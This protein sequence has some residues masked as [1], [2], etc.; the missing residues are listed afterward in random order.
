MRGREPLPVLRRLAKTTPLGRVLA[1]PLRARLAAHY[2]VR[3]VLSALRWLVASREYTNFTYDLQP[4]NLGHLASF[5]AHVAGRPVAEVEGY[6]GEILGDEALRGHVRRVTR[7]SPF[8]WV[9]DE[10]ARYGRRIGWYAFVRALKPRVVVETGVDKGLGAVILCAA[11]M[12]NAQ[13]GAPG[14]YYGTDINPTAGYLLRPPYS[15]FGQVLYGDSIESL[16]ALRG[17]IDLFVNDSDHSADYEARE[18][19]TVAPKLAPG[20]VV[21]GDNAEVTDQLRDF[22]LRTDRDFLYFQERPLGHWYPGGG[23]GVA[24]PRTRLA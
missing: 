15:A 19:V 9:G 8:R 12:R 3:P 16:E 1:L 11:L 21:L 10:E 14:T 18:Y 23:I 17:P 4:R 13:E 6:I 5:V 2:T 24:F 22:A 20:A 7:E